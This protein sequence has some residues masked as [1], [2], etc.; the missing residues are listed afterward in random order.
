MPGSI[1][2][3]HDGAA[4]ARVGPPQ[5]DA[6]ADGVRYLRGRHGQ[7]LEQAVQRLGWVE[8]RAP[9]IMGM[10]VEVERPVRVP[11]GDQAGRADRQRGLS[12]AWH[13]LDYGDPGD[14][15]VLSGEQP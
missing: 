1:V 3:D 14:A 12:H 4:T 8:R 15:A 7:H 6:L 10:K 9:G 5:R 2:E 11:P 13:A